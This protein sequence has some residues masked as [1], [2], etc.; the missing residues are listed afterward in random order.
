MDKKEKFKDL[1]IA[2]I[3][4]MTMLDYPGHI[5]AVV[6]LQGC[7][8]RC[9]YCHNPEMQ[10]IKKGD[11]PIED[12]FDLIEKRKGLLDGFVFSGGDPLIYPKLPD[13]LKFVKSQG[14][15][16]ALHTGGYMV[17]VFE[18]SLI[19]TDWVG[20]DMKAPFE[21]YE[22]VAKA[23]KSG[24]KA[25]KSMEIL[26][27]SGVDYEIRTTASPDDLTIEDIYKISYDLQALK[28]KKFVLQE[29]RTMVG[30]KNDRAKDFLKSSSFFKDE[31]LMKHLENAFDKFEIRRA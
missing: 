9:P 15:K 30:N 1:P 31:K 10:E 8:F 29:H 23:K 17:D 19:Y 5:S 13:L 27:K 28:V 16:T 12:F 4:K 2:G 14:Y 3:T 24:E 26:I 25:K 6:F 7:P 21:S 11:H 20:M 22:K 18:K